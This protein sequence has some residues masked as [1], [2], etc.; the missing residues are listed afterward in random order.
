MPSS[1][2]LLVVRMNLRRRPTNRISSQAK[3]EVLW[4][5]TGL[6]RFARNAFLRRYSSASR[7][8]SSR[9]RL[10]SSGSIIPCT[11]G[12]PLVR[13][14]ALIFVQRQRVEGIGQKVD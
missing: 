5:T 13:L 9:R 7:I 1:P 8:S 10:G 11:F 4:E 12:S 3:V 6:L 2:A 14:S